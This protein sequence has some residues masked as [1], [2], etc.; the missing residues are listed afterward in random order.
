MS[1]KDIEKQ[2]KCVR[3]GVRKHYTENSEKIKAYKKKHYEYK[4]ECRRLMDILIDL[5]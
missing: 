3:E 1:Y 2:R 4:K 5:V